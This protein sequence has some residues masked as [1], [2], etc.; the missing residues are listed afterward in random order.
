MSLSHCRMGGH[1]LSFFFE[2]SNFLGRRKNK[3]QA[4]TDAANEAAECDFYGSHGVHY[5]LCLT[6]YNIVLASG[7]FTNQTF[8]SAIKGM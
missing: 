7:E 6:V 2:G 8:L 5:G 3:S 4:N 1:L